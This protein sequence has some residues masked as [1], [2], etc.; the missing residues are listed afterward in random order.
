MLGLMPA[1]AMQNSNATQPQ[2]TR[3][4][5]K[6]QDGLPED[7]VQA[8][9]ETSDGYLWIGTTGGLTRFDGTRF[10]LY[11]LS[12]PP[13]TGV[14]SVFCLEPSRDGGLWIGTEGGGLLHLLKGQVRS[15]GAAEGL[16]DSFVRSVLED[17]RGVVWVGTDNGLFQVKDDKIQRVEM[18]AGMGPLAVHAISEDRQNRIWIGG[19]RLLSIT[20]GRQLFYGLPGRYSSNRV[21][22]V[23]ETKDGTVWVG[24]VSGLERLV[25]QKFERVPEIVGTVRTL[26][27]TSDGTLWIGTIGNGLWTYKDGVFLRLKTL[28]PDNTVLKIFE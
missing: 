17:R 11:G 7:T 1:R 9:A 23:L 26:K 10:V 18:P 25:G 14:N 8:L 15:Y 16:T 24:T 12:E 5:W 21:K 4:V 13:S 28:L 27:Q 2:Y 6:V 20:D 22:T 19:S 3:T